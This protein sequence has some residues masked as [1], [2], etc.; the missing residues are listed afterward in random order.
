MQTCR[1]THT[2]HTPCLH[3]HCCL[4]HN[5]PLATQCQVSDR[6]KSYALSVFGGS[7]DRGACTARRPHPGP[8]RLGQLSAFLRSRQCTMVAGRDHAEHLDELGGRWRPRDRRHRC[9]GRPRG[10]RGGRAW[11]ACPRAR[12]RVALYL[13][14][15]V[16]KL[17]RAKVT[18]RYRARS[19]SGRARSRAAAAGTGAEDV[20]S[21]HRWHSA[22][23]W[24]RNLIHSRSGEGLA[25]RFDHAPDHFGPPLLDHFVHPPFQVI[26]RCS[27]VV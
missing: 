9:S 23:R 14:H 27:E 7:S 21:E 6:V 1:W 25:D 13:T 3:L 8:S 17:P 5:V 15:A 4:I 12:D 18:D 16:A 2:F 22:A 24:W 10:H 20:E 26:P 19:V 11:R